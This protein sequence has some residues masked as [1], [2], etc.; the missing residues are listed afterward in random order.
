MNTANTPG[1]IRVL[2]DA[3]EKARDGTVV[4]VSL[5]CYDNNWNWHLTSAGSVLRFP[6]VGVAAAQSLSSEMQRRIQKISP[7]KENRRA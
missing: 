2:E 1:I 6:A 5:I 7:A 4:G 3:I